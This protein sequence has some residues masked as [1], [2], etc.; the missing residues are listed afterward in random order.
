MNICRASVEVSFCRYFELSSKESMLTILTDGG[1][2]LCN[3]LDAAEM[4][5]CSALRRS[6]CNLTIS[7]TKSNKNQR[8]L[9][10]YRATDFKCKIDSV[11]NTEITRCI[12]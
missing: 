6:F 5:K 7:V 2:I 12:S 11:F 4:L 3:R 9:Y 10:H 8:I 1:I